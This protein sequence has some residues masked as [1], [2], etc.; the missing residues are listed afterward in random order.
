VTTEPIVSASWLLRLARYGLGTWLTLYGLVAAFSPND[1]IA[2][3]GLD[4]VAAAVNIQ[5]HHL[6]AGLFLIP[7]VLVLIP[8]LRT[9]GLAVATMFLTTFEIGLIV[10]T[11]RGDGTS[12]APITFAFAIGVSAVLLTLRDVR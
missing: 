4:D 12:T 9:F 7:G 1:R 10:S 6:L 2:S 3:S 8:R 11:V 5:P